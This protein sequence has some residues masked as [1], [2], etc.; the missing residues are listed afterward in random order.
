LR[1]DSAPPAGCLPGRGKTGEETRC[2]QRRGG[3]ARHSN[4]PSVRPAGGSSSQKRNSWPV[5]RPGRARRTVSLSHFF[6]HKP[7][8]V[9]SWPAGICGHAGPQVPRGQ[10]C[11]SA[12]RSLFH[13]ESKA[14]PWAFAGSRRWRFGFAFIGACRHPIRGSARR[15]VGETQRRKGAKAQRCER[16]AILERLGGS[17]ALVLGLRPGRSTFGGFRRFCRPAGSVSRQNGVHSKVGRDPRSQ[18]GCG[19]QPQSRQ[20]GVHNKGE[21]PAEPWIRPLLGLYARRG[22]A[23]PAGFSGE[24]DSG[25]KQTGLSAPPGGQ[26]KTPSA[27]GAEGGESVQDRIRTCR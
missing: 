20:N 2:F 3:A 25:G 8:A 18:S 12:L 16:G 11:F 15:G 26:E 1:T 23:G 4:R 17:L 24:A 10:S 22:S 14:P 7:R 21:A 19:F 6:Q 13:R 27:S 9:Q 5:G